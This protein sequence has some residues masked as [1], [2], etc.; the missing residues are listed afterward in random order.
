MAKQN[1]VQAT[2]D[3]QLSLLSDFD[4]E[5]LAHADQG[6]SDSQ[7]DNIIPQIRVL[8]PLSPE[9][10]DGKIEGAKAG[11]LLLGET[12][13]RGADGI[14]FQP[15]AQVHRWFEFRPIDEGGGFVAEH[16]VQLDQHGKE[17]VG[18]SGDPIPPRGTTA[19]KRYQHVFPNGN[20]AVHYRQWAGVAWVDGVGLEYAINF[21]STGHTTA[22]QWMSKAR[23][24]YHSGDP[25]KRYPLWSHVY[26]LTT[27]KRTNNAGTWFV[28]DVG[29]PVRLDSCSD[30]GDW[31]MANA[32]GKGLA[33]AFS[34]KEKTAAV[35]GEE[36]QQTVEAM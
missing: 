30:V 28:I 26:K 4:R 25:T 19:V 1:V 32:K 24:L 27:S 36:Q 29:S 3:K 12:L 10:V 16:P 9:I 33:E 34:K 5:M 15:C 35:E 18:G 31:K 17:V 8:Q 20:E 11:D 23:G 7:L 22:K 21:K 6:I 13:V 14:W 2:D